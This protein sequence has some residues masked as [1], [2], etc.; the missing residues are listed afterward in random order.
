MRSRLLVV[1]LAVVA[2][3]PFLGKAFHIDDPLFLWM[4]E[5]VALHPLD[6]YRF[7][8]NW[9]SYPRPMWDEMQNPPLCSYYIAAVLAVVGKSEI[10]L[11]AAFLVWPI[12][13]LLGVFQLALRFKVPP[14]LAAL[15]TLFTPVF[16]VSATNLMCDVMMLAFFVWAIECWAR[17]LEKENFAPLFLAVA[18]VVAATLTKYFGIALVP[19]LLVYTLARA[20]R[21]RPGT[22]L[23]LIPLGVTIGY[24]FLTKAAYGRGLFLAAGNMAYGAWDKSHLSLGPQAIVGLCFAGGCLLTQLFFFGARPFS[25]G[26]ALVAGL[27]AF[28]LVPLSPAW[29][30][31]NNAPFVRIEGGIFAGAGGLLLFRAAEDFWR[32]RDAEGL[33]LALW[34]FGTFI[35]SVFLN[36]SITARTILPMA[37]AV[38]L[39]T[40]R[41]VPNL[42]QARVILGVG[43]AAVISIALAAG[44]FSEANASRRAAA[45]FGERFRAE[46][47][48]VW[49]QSHWGFQYYMQQWAARPINLLDFHF[50]SGDVIVIP[51]NNTAIR[52]IDTSAVFTPEEVR[53]P[54]VPWIT[55]FARTSGACFYSS[56]RGPLPWAVDSFPPALFYVAR[57]R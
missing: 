45:A 16:M 46:P 48:T 51:A 57:F 39:L 21:W 26:G 44:D 54:L 47:G 19:L 2:L 7:E 24:E 6:P 33:L 15:L 53:F 56:T 14:L 3:G 34:I 8:V 13:A 20:R 49:F 42:S 9:S 23:L 10:A 22:L 5:Q 38:A 37:P 4:G 28:F 35:F 32:R 18:L 25:L 36:W 30:L 31:G 50:A 40:L 29:A 43:A 11:H 41:S 1:L 17:G 27:L 52:Q 12:L 55:T